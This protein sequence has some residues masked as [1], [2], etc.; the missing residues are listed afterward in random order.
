VL[1]AAGLAK[2]VTAIARQREAAAFILDIQGWFIQSDKVMKTKTLLTLFSVICAGSIIAQTPSYTATEAAKHVGETAMVADRVDGVH[3]SGKGNIFLNMGGKYPNQAFTAFIP[4]ASAGQ[5]PQ[6]QQYE[7]RT[8]AVSGKITL[9]HG[10]PE[11]VVNSS[12][13]I[14][15]K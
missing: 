8:V 13:Q 3:Q 5:F 10:K 15:A 12:S 11:I 9:Y 14:S 6:P 1:I 4:A 2:P 7:G